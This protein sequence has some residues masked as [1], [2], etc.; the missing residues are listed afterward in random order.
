MAQ[1]PGLFPI[2]PD[3]PV[4]PFHVSLSLPAIPS[5]ISKLYGSTSSAILLVP[6]TDYLVKFV[7]GDLGIADNLKKSMMLKNINACKNEDVFKHF[8]KMV[9]L[10]IPDPSKFKTKNG[11]SVPKG[12]ISVDPSDDLMGIKAME[13]TI[14]KSIFETQK[15]Y[16]E[17]AKLVVENVAKIEDIIA[18]IMPLL[19]PG[20]VATKLAAKSE[21]PKTNAGITNGRPKAL[22]YNQGQSV[23]PGLGKLQS[24]ANKG[25]VVKL[26][27]NGNTTTTPPR[28]DPSAVNVT[29]PESNT[30]DAVSGEF[31][32][33]STVYSTGEFDPKV[34]YKYIYKDIIDDSI[35]DGDLAEPGDISIGDD[36]PYA[37][38]KPKRVI[39]GIFNSKGEPLNPFKKLQALDAYGNKVDTPFYAADWITRSPKWVFPNNINNQ[40]GQFYWNRFGSPYYYWERWGEV[41][42]SQTEPSPGENNPSYTKKTYE[43]GNRKGE[44][45][46]DYS[47]TNEKQDFINYFTHLVSLKINSSDGLDAQEKQDSINTVINKLYEKDEEGTIQVGPYTLEKTQIDNHLDNCSK[48]GVLGGATFINPN[49]GQPM[50]V[51]SAMR[52]PLKPGKFNLG[53][54]DVW[55]DPESDYD[56]K[57]IKVDSVLDIGY[58]DVQGEPEV[59][60]QILS[61]IKNSISITVTGDD[62]ST[63]L[64]FSISVAKNQNAPTASE[65]I[66]EYQLDNWNY[67][68]EDGLLGTKEPK[69]NN[70]NVYN[71]E[72]WRYSSNPFFVGK[73]EVTFP[74]QNDT[75][76]EMKNESNSSSLI[77]S[78]SGVEETINT[79]ENWTYMEYKKTFETSTINAIPSGSA[80]FVYDVEGAPVS[81]GEIVTKVH[82]GAD[83]LNTNQVNRVYRWYYRKSSTGITDWYTTPPSSWF[84]ANF[85]LSWQLSGNISTYPNGSLPPT[86][87]VDVKEFN[88]KKTF[89]GT[90]SFW[91]FDDPKLRKETRTYQ[92]VANGE[93]T[94]GEQSLVEVVDYK[95]KRWI[96]WRQSVGLGSS[97]NNKNIMPAYQRN[98]NVSLLYNTFGNNQT[99]DTTLT[100]D[101]IP[102]F[103]VR[104]KDTSKYGKMIDPSKI[105]NNHLT[106]PELYSSS[107]YGGSPQEVGFLRRYMRTELDTETYYIIE[108]IL[109]DENIQNGPN[110]GNQNNAN[111]NNQ[112]GGGTEWYRMPSAL[113][114]VKVFLSI[115]SDIFAKLIPAIKKLLNLFKNPAKFVTD[116]ISEKLGE[117]FLIFSPEAMAVMKQLPNIPIPQR[118]A[119]VKKSVLNNYISVNPDGSYRFLLDGAG[120][121]KLPILG[122]TI[123]FG[124]ELAMLK[125]IIKLIF[126]IDFNE[127]PNNSLD[128]FLSKTDLAY[129][130]SP[131]DSL[132]NINVDPSNAVKNTVVTESNGK[133]NVE[134]V[135]IVYSTGKFIQGVDYQYIYVTEYVNKLIQEADELERTNDPDNL[136]EAKAKLDL[137]L[138]S[139]PNNPVIK[140]KLDDLIKKTKSYIQP[141]LK[142]LIEIVSLPIKIIA[143]IIQWLMDFFQS[144]SNPMTLPS[145]MKDFISFKW[146]LDFVKPDKLLELAGIKFD[147]QKLLDWIKNLKNYPAGYEFDL[148][149]VIDIALLTKMPK[150]KKEQFIDMLKKPFRILFSILCFL[151]SLI[152]GII[153]FIWALMGIEV[154]IPAPHIKLCRQLNDNLTPEDMMDILN[155]LMKDQG[156]LKS[157]DIGNQAGTAGAGGNGT[158]ET[159]D[160]IYDIKLSDGRTLRE[161]N[162]EELRQ[163]IEDNKNISFDFLF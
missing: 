3:S 73:S 38:L 45:I 97:I 93:K 112:S 92:Q 82:I 118:E 35:T 65:N 66:T 91:I 70:Q 74:I 120:L 67:D 47:G 11:Y 111:P 84:T 137:A 104:V 101:N 154:I 89:T 15:P 141:I 19:T 41:I 102:A 18:R 78:G 122:N 99:L 83:T 44:Y 79:Q 94:L 139:D 9:K 31:E 14:I 33:I 156:P 71:I 114:A 98:N 159:Y 163:F 85:E 149:E 135:S 68:D 123:T 27:R 121:M 61:F 37:K 62:G 131:I 24:L 136:E 22:G 36:D 10:D 39:F 1:L 77:N 2:Y 116:I 20:D 162:E 25:K 4:G 69:I 138:K 80:S 144:L 109:Q 12:L 55:M 23:K 161:L 90:A 125:P 106:N 148:S 17:I 150:V 96:V 140:A 113:G 105:T 115:L 152:N 146:I 157:S 127:I 6:N 21:K 7:N 32:I 54:N 155:G 126:S 117:N 51:P 59:N 129:K 160:F 153:D 29:Q 40:G 57:I 28:T 130:K 48:Y 46:I 143:G 133:E 8:A 108:G 124:M 86:K 16:V 134:E 58:N 147:I 64:P 30:S 26:D 145:K 34:D 142:F 60:A 107:K 151:E 42:R 43:D 50:S 63:K 119:F 13:K 110:G 87:V 52:F 5:E 158:G 75:Y 72:M 81:G 132:G 95:V 49:N 128:S 56:L 76:I 103:Q 53:G 88:I 100:I